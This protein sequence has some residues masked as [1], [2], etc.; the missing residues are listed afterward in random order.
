MKNLKF[1]AKTHATSRR[2]RLETI[3]V[4]ALGAWAATVAVAADKAEA[5]PATSGAPN[6]FVYR[7]PIVSEAIDGGIRDP[8][9]INWNK[10]YY[11]TGT[12]PPTIPTSIRAVWPW[13]TKSPALTPF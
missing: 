12:C 5:T 7:N 13:R 4:C 10:K 3:A 6:T 2:G 1:S 11:L 8:H 9:I